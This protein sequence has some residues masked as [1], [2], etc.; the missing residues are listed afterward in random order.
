[1]TRIE[2]TIT[3]AE[4]ALLDRGKMDRPFYPKGEEQQIAVCRLVGRGLMTINGTY[5]RDNRCF[6]T[7]AGT[8]ALA[9]WA[10]RKRV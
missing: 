4:A 10:G 2:I 5:W 3:D 6:T 9:E 7:F 8:C 1:M